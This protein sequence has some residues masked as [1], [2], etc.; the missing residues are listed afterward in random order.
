[1]ARIQQG[2]SLESFRNTDLETEKQSQRALIADQVPRIT[3]VSI[4]DDYVHYNTDM[5]RTLSVRECARL[6]T[7]PDHFRIY[8]SR[9]TGGVRRKN[10]CPQ[11]TQVGNA[12][13]PR[14]AK[15]M[16]KQIRFLLNE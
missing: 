4:P 5:P 10:D 7:F 12:V 2:Y 9:T 16:A 1:M 14:L 15:A 13:P 6:Q 8:G 3:I 11:Y